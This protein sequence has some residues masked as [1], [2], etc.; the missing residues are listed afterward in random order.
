MKG[1]DRFEVVVGKVT[2][3][4]SAHLFHAVTELLV[5]VD[6]LRYDYSGI[7]PY[8]LLHLPEVFDTRSHCLGY[9]QNMVFRRRCDSQTLNYMVAVKYLLL[10]SD[11]VDT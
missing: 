6:N 2:H 8:L 3:H 4:T 11:F 1:L 5:Y 7:P 9:I 10:A